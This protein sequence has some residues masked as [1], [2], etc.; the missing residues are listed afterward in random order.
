MITKGEK[1]WS[2][3]AGSGCCK[4]LPQSP[5]QGTN[6]A[7]LPLA[8][9]GLLTTLGGQHKENALCFLWH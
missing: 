5:L 3:L 9:S 8:G 1:T 4:V 6:K 2:L 7:S